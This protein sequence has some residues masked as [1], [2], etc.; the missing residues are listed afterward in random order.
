[1]NPNACHVILA[2]RPNRGVEMKCL[3]CI[4]L[5][6]LATAWVIGQPAH[7]AQPAT[8]VNTPEIMVKSLYHDVVARAPSGLLYGSNMRIFAPYLSRSL[9]R[10]IEAARAC[11]RDWLQQNRGRMVKA[12]FFWSE[13]GI[14]TGP[15]ERTSPGDFHIE[16]TQAEKNGAFRVIVSFTYRPIDGSGSW[17]VTVLV[18][19]EDGRF[20]VDDVI[21]PKDE[22]RDVDLTLSKSL[23]M[24]KSL[25]KGCRGA[26]GPVIGLP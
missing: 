7:T 15:T 10:K 18:V 13:A 26:G 6:F 16:S 4:V 8:S 11:E 1:M 20:V 17:H 25:S 21:F 23:S 5:M 12:P 14:F 3:R 2:N 24:S 9:L 22:T 19:R